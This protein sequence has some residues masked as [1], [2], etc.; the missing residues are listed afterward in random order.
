MKWIT[1][2]PDYAC[3]FLTRH[4]NKFR[5]RNEYNLWRF[6]WV[7]GEPPENAKEDTNYYYL[8]WLTNDWDEWDDIGECDYDEYLVLEKLPTLEELKQ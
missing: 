7:Q 8:A 3:V 2:R 5:N 4:W 1:K 6:E